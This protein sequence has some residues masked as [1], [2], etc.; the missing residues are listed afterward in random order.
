MTNAHRTIT[1]LLAVIAVLLAINLSVTV[2]SHE[3]QAQAVGPPVEAVALQA[4][5][6]GLLYRMFSDGT[7]ERNFGFVELFGDQCVVDWCG[8]E[9]I[10]EIP[11]VP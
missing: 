1:T 9:A 11:F 10:P 4:G 3:A 5:E 8:W 7:V 2:P 6:F